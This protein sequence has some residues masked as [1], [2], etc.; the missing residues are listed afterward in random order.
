[1]PLTIEP[2]VRWD[3]SPLSPIFWE[4]AT[5]AIVGPTQLEYF[6]RTGLENIDHNYW[7]IASYQGAAVWIRSDRLRSRKAFREQRTIKEVE[8][9]GEV[10]R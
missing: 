10:H 2:A 5:G 9:I 8:I 4:C 1:M 7:V 6:V 3:G